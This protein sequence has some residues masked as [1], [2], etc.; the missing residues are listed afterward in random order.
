MSSPGVSSNTSFYFSISRTRIK[1]SFA[2]TFQNSDSTPL[3][4][5]QNL[6]VINQLLHAK[7]VSYQV[8]N[9]LCHNRRKTTSLPNTKPS[10]HLQCFKKIHQTI[11]AH[12]LVTSTKFARHLSHKTRYA[13]C[14]LKCQ[15]NPFLFDKKNS[16][17]VLLIW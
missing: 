5:L 6:S 3:L 4:P 1:L 9:T 17:F 11:F 13:N 10:A 16:F 8:A 2:A 7:T 15:R 12:N 14:V